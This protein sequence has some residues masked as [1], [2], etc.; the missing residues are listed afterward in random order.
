MR[1]EKSQGILPIVPDARRTPPPLPGHPQPIPGRSNPS[2]DGTQGNP[3]PVTAADG[4]PATALPA[5]DGGLSR[6]PSRRSPQL[7]GQHLLGVLMARQVASKQIMS[8]SDSGSG[9]SSGRFYHASAAGGNGVGTSPGSAPVDIPPANSALLLEAAGGNAAAAT[10]AP[11]PPPRAAVTAEAP[12]APCS[13]LP[14]EERTPPP[15]PPAPPAV[16]PLGITPHAIAAGSRGCRRS[17]PNM[18]MG[19]VA[20]NIRPVGARRSLSP[21]PKDQPR[22]TRTS[23]SR[24]ARTLS[25][26]TS[27]ASPHALA[28]SVLLDVPSSPGGQMQ[29]RPPLQVHTPCSP[30]LEDPGASS[31]SFHTGS[32]L[33][34]RV[35]RIQLVPAAP[36]HPLTAAVKG[37]SSRQSAEAD[38][39]PERMSCPEVFSAV[40]PSEAAA[41]NDTSA[42]AVEVPPLADRS[43]FGSGDNKQMSMLADLAAAV[44]ELQRRVAE[45]SPRLPHDTT[46]VSDTG[47]GYSWCTSTRSSAPGNVNGDSSCLSIGPWAPPVRGGVSSSGAS[48]AMTADRTTDE[49]L[50]VLELQMKHVA[51]A[52]RDVAASTSTLSPPALPGS[53]K[54]I[55]TGAIGSG[56]S[57]NWT[58]T[59]EAGGVPAEKLPP[60]PPTCSGS[61][62][63]GEP[64]MHSL[65][66]PEG[67]SAPFATAM[68]LALGFMAA[69]ATMWQK[70]L[71]GDGIGPS[72]ASSASLRRPRKRMLPPGLA[73][74]EKAPEAPATVGLVPLGA[75]PPAVEAPQAS[76]FAHSPITGGPAAAE[77][78]AVEQLRAVAQHVQFLEGRLQELGRAVTVQTDRAMAA[79]ATATAAA[80]DDDEQ[81]LRQLQLRAAVEEALAVAIQN[82]TPGWAQPQQQL[83]VRMQACEERVEQLQQRW[84]LI[85]VYDKATQANDTAAAPDASGAEDALSG[86]ANTGSDAGARISSAAAVVAAA[87]STTMTTMTAMPTTTT[88]TTEKE[89]LRDALMPGLSV[90]EALMSLLAPVEVTQDPIG[91]KTLPSAPQVDAVAA[92]GAA[93]AVTA[94]AATGSYVAGNGSNGTAATLHPMASFPIEP[95]LRELQQLLQ[96]LVQKV[97]NIAMEVTSARAQSSSCAGEIQMILEQVCAVQATAAAANA[98]ARKA[99]TAALAAERAAAAA[100]DVVDAA[101]TIPRVPGNGLRRRSRST[102]GDDAASSGGGVGGLQSPMRS[103]VWLVSPRYTAAPVATAVR[104]RKHGSEV[105]VEEGNE[106]VKDEENPESSTADAAPAMSLPTRRLAARDVGFH[107]QPDGTDVAIGGAASGASLYGISASR[108][109]LLEA[110][111]ARLSE[112]EA[113]QKEL[114]SK[115]AKAL[116]LRV[117]RDELKESV[118][119]LDLRI[120]SAIEEMGAA[121]GGGSG[122]A[123]YGI[124]SIGLRSSMSARARLSSDGCGTAGCGTVSGGGYGDDGSGADGGNGGDEGA[125]AVVAA[126]GSRVAAGRHATGRGPLVGAVAPGRRVAA[127]AHQGRQVAAATSSNVADSVRSPIGGGGAASSTGLSAE[128]SATLTQL[129]RS[130]GLIEQRLEVVEAGVAQCDA[131]QVALS[132]NLQQVQQQQF[133]AQLQ[134]QLLQPP[135]DRAFTAPPQPY[136]RNGSVA[137][138]Y[139]N[140]GSSAALGSDEQLI[141]IAHR[142]E[143]NDEAQAEL[144]RQVRSLVE[145]SS[146]ATTGQ[147]QAR[148]RDLVRNGA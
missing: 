82:A 31:P 96:E 60:P 58:G 1:R 93:A 108:P 119:Q 122:R 79:T 16:T 80:A 94:A 30:F 139:G 81:R 3:L 72:P 123:A 140:A 52:I 127:W 27:T 69:A 53:A 77:V 126:D 148:G 50:S 39:L 84:P 70:T 43:G 110:A 142:I 143:L 55:A 103:E 49:R 26:G 136:S 97:Q 73:P 76:S 138:R 134:L 63:S 86:A 11:T 54:N 67:T 105:Q 146:A 20:P 10:G 74:C 41:A 118:A 92:A 68:G 12:N 144:G 113:E 89:E 56:G 135:Q 125:A 32:L 124:A 25:P 4:F 57:N 22:L 90:D 14:R 7:P 137:R 87:E 147:G 129:Q 2:S 23:T 83:E 19:V 17:L 91:L 62:E 47:S 28:S 51:A 104:L 115:V 107:I 44:G 114:R 75:R 120:R 9:A 36:L 130:V 117:T 40:M 101:A 33:S 38:D 34:P 109:C 18:V 46:G 78:E 112:M 100:L 29:P 61:G 88:T 8:T 133:Q 99:S 59:R 21:N 37:P 116:V 145:Q 131:A 71:D 15:T 42:S 102:S 45:M 132:A 24:G 128:L 48:V 35:M 121:V 5:V 13:G 66:A 111:L 106:D 98:N 95:S 65:Q 141:S 6:S 64:Y 85:Q